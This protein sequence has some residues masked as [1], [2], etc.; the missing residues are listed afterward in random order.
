[1]DG[2]PEEPAGF[3]EREPGEEAPQCENAELLRWAGLQPEA[4]EALRAMVRRGLPRDPARN[5]RVARWKAL[6]LLRD[7]RALQEAQPV[8][9]TC[10]D[11]RGLG[12]EGA[13]QDHPLC[14]CEGYRCFERGRVEQRRRGASVLLPRLRV[15]AQ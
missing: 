6:A 8:G 4:A 14:Q 3:L 15:S 11:L 1:M 13:Q 10:P 5:A 7:V 9:A 12:A 2:E